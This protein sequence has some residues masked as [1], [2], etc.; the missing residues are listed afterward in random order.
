M[1]KLGGDAECPRWQSGKCGLTG[2]EVNCLSR[3]N[4]CREEGRRLIADR[5]LRPLSVWLRL[6]RRAG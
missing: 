5:G 3:L 1:L 4:R 6:A 2:R